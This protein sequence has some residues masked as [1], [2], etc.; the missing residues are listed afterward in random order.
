V[1]FETTSSG[2]ENLWISTVVYG[3]YPQKVKVEEAAAQ[4]C[5]YRIDQGEADDGDE[6]TEGSAEA[7]DEP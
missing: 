6:S 2:R 4:V 1:D 3:E 7:C 5:C